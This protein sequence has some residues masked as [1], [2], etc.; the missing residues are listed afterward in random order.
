MRQFLFA[1]LWGIICT[2]AFCGYALPNDICFH[3]VEG[4]PVAPVFDILSGGGQEVS[5]YA[6]YARLN[7]MQAVAAI[8]MNNNEV[9]DNIGCRTDNYKGIADYTSIYSKINTIRVLADNIANFAEDYES[10]IE[11]VIQLL[12]QEGDPPGTHT[13]FGFVARAIEQII[14]H[15]EIL[16][17]EQTIGLPRE[18]GTASLFGVINSIIYELT[19][20]PLAPLLAKINNKMLAIKD[21]AQEKSYGAYNSPIFL[22]AEHVIDLITSSYTI[23]DY[24]DIIKCNQI[25]GTN[26]GQA[27][28]TLLEILNQTMQAIEE[29][30]FLNFWEVCKVLNCG[31]PDGTDDQGEDSTNTES[32]TIAGYFHSLSSIFLKKIE[33]ILRFSDYLITRIE[34]KIIVLND[35]EQDLFLDIAEKIQEIAEEL[36]RSTFLLRIEH[37][38]NIVP[39]LSEI[40]RILYRLSQEAGYDNAAFAR[41]MGDKYDSPDKSTLCGAMAR[42]VNEIYILELINHLEQVGEATPPAIQKKMDLLA[43]TLQNSSPSMDRSLYNQT[44]NIL[45]DYAQL[46]AIDAT[47]NNDVYP[48]VKRI[49]GRNFCTQAP[50]C[51]RRTAQTEHKNDEPT[52]FL[53]LG[54]DAP[55]N[56]DVIDDLLYKLYRDSNII[57]LNKAQDSLLQIVKDQSVMANKV[58]VK[59]MLQNINFADIVRKLADHSSALSKQDALDLYEIIGVPGSGAGNTI[60]SKISSLGASFSS[61]SLGEGSSPDEAGSTEERLN[62]SGHDLHYR[63]IGDISDIRDDIESPS[64]NTLYGDSNWIKNKLELAECSCQQV[65]ADLITLASNI[66]NFALA[67]NFFAQNIDIAIVRYP[68]I[69]DVI[70]AITGVFNL[71]YE[72]RAAISKIKKIMQQHAEP[73]QKCYLFQIKRYINNISQRLSSFSQSILRIFAP[74]DGSNAMNQQTACRMKNDN[75]CNLLSDAIDAIS[76]EVGHV[77]AEYIALLDAIGGILFLPCPEKISKDIK[78][79]NEMFIGVLEDLRSLSEIDVFCSNADTDPGVTCL[80]KKFETIPVPDILSVNIARDACCSQQIFQIDQISELL[81]SFADV[82][83]AALVNNTLEEHILQKTVNECV[84]MLANKFHVIFQEIQTITD[85]CAAGARTTCA[86]NTLEKNMNSIIRCLYESITILE[87]FAQKDYDADTRPV[88]KVSNFEEFLGAH[89]AQNRS[90]LDVREDSSIGATPKLPKEQSFRN[91]STER[92]NNSERYIC[93]NLPYFLHKLDASLMCVYSVLSDEHDSILSILKNASALSYNKDL[94]DIILTFANKH[95]PAAIPTAL[96]WNCADDAVAG[97]ITTETKQIFGTFGLLRDVLG[98]IVN[99][100]SRPRCC[101]AVYALLTELDAVLARSIDLFCDWFRLFCD[102]TWNE[103]T[104]STKFEKIKDS[105][106]NIEVVVRQCIWQTIQAVANKGKRCCISYEAEPYLADVCDSLLALEN[107]LLE[108]YPLEYATQ[109]PSLAP[110]TAG[111]KNTLEVPECVGA[112]ILSC[113]HSIASTIGQCWPRLIGIVQDLVQASGA[114]MPPTDP[115]AKLDGVMAALQQLAPFLSDISKCLFM[116]CDYLHNIQ[117]ANKEWCTSCDSAAISASIKLIA[118][119]IDRVLGSILALSDFLA[120]VKTQATM[121]NFNA[122]LAYGVRSLSLIDENGAVIY[123]NKNGEHS[124]TLPPALPPE[125]IVQIEEPLCYPYFV[126]NRPVAKVSNFEEFLGAHEAQ[127]HSV[128]NVRKDS[129]IGATLK[130]PKERCFRN[131][132]NNQ[133][134]LCDCTGN[135]KNPGLTGCNIHDFVPIKA[136]EYVDAAITAAELAEIYLRKLQKAFTK[137]TMRSWA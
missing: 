108:C 105:I 10:A 7:E 33:R 36:P 25:I 116:L 88:E 47:E 16:A 20:A 48:V 17:I 110:S 56:N 63:I 117:L 24:Q 119:N 9:L 27:E 18:K 115:A 51:T 86:A 8:H 55:E 70:N 1:T 134:V 92:T 102:G 114:E 109:L 34:P 128:L 30:T 40:L 121:H 132:S 111:F 85:I 112:N 89:E 35:E 69:S 122:L 65:G 14:N 22:F 28:G 80:N 106:D 101:V 137:N 67:I 99:E 100:L 75:C 79:L 61:D 59:Q 12:G 130:L 52:N 29:S 2:V 43:V 68:A 133:Q 38:G 136:T 103:S 26:D 90:V 126:Y 83:H 23:I 60:F 74:H 73:A 15:A 21:A 97:E 71:F 118:S 45:E 96:C 129:S 135:I 84:Y 31:G 57:H 77:L 3:D 66:Q 78:F 6:I 72:I 4:P 113:I 13:V 19:I 124:I 54:I 125:E 123:R 41:I 131:R 104:D 53:Q 32:P 44:L 91:R 82:L 39:T 42:L 62:N 46:Q 93:S 76:S 11:T 98:E 94:I 37:F 50:S 120:G 58:A 5:W 107:V 87:I 64:V 49:G 95:V 127:N 81:L